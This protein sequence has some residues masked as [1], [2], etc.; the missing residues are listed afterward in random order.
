VPE[1]ILDL[2]IDDLPAATPPAMPDRLRT[3]EPIATTGATQQHV[4]LTQTTES[5]TTFLGINGVPFDKTTPLTAMVG[6]TNIWEV[7]NTTDAHHPF[8]LHGFFFQVLGAD[9]RPLTD[10]WKDTLNVPKKETRKVIV[11]YDDRP[12]MWMFH[13]H[14]LDHAD[15]GMMG[16]LNLMRSGGTAAHSAAH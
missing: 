13:C 9:G 7:V 10:E 4:E 15:L 12:G 3:I 5:G 8:H 6:D 14:I 11:K 2:Q 1:P 16:M